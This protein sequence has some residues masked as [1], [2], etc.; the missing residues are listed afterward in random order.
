MACWTLSKFHCRSIRLAN[1][2]T[3]TSPLDF[4]LWKTSQKP[5]STSSRLLARPP[6]N[7][8]HIRGSADQTGLTFRS[9]ILDSHTQFRWPS[10]LEPKIISH[11]TD[12]SCSRSRCSALFWPNCLVLRQNNNLS[13]PKDPLVQPPPLANHTHS[14]S[15]WDFPLWYGRT[16]NEQTNKKAN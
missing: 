8:S 13:E 10:P 12:S 5:C 4:A 16:R 9:S 15:G 1:K 11:H 3:S 14:E 2:Y 7:S 6:A